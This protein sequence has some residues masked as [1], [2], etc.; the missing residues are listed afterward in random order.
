MEMFIAEAQEKD[1]LKIAVLE[2]RLF[3]IKY[4]YVGDKELLTGQ[5]KFNTNTREFFHPWSIKAMGKTF[6]AREYSRFM[7]MIDYFNFPVDL[8]E[9]LL[10]GVVEGEQEAIKAKQKAAQQAAAAAG[11]NQDPHKAALALAQR[12]QGKK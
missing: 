5:L 9:D 7:P 6:G 4:G 1:P 12:E 3:M 2:R 8:I 10:E 11:G